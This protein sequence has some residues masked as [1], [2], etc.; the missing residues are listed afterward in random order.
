MRNIKYRGI[1]P[2]GDYVFGSLFTC[3]LDDN[4]K[5]YIILKEERL[6]KVESFDFDIELIFGEHQ[7]D[8]VTP[9]SVSQFTGMVDKKGTEIY[10]ND[11][12]KAL[13]RGYSVHPVVGKVVYDKGAFMLDDG[14]GLLYF[15]REISFYSENLEVVWQD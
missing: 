1:N 13:F 8:V 6:S 11:R 14:K 4:T 10:E 12:V 2:E 7:V 15:G 3:L 9:E 5:G